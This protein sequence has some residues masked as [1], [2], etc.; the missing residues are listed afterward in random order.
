[1]YLKQQ[2]LNMLNRKDVLRCIK[3]RVYA[4]SSLIR[5]FKIIRKL[6]DI[7]ASKVI[8]IQIEFQKL[9]ILVS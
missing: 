7:E 2:L 9:N 4:L 6:I 8:I 3:A 1:M 5:V